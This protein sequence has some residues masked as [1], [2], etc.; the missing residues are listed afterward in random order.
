MEELRTGIYFTFDYFKC[1]FP[2]L[3]N[4][5]EFEKTEVDRLREEI[6]K[7]LNIDKDFY[8]EDYA[9][10]YKY[11]YTI[12]E[13][14]LLRCCGP[15]FSN[16]KPSCYI[17]FKGKGCREFEVLNP[18]K[19]WDDLLKHFVL[20]YD[21]NVKRIDIAIDHFDNKPVS[22]DW[23][24]N[25]LNN[26]YF[27]SNFKNRNFNLSGNIV[28]GRSITFGRH[29]NSLMLC[30]YEK[31]KEQEYH[32]EIVPEEHWTRYEMRFANNRADDFAY[33]YLTIS[34]MPLNEF[35]LSVFYQMLDIKEDN[36]RDTH[37]QANVETDPKWL[38][39]LGH[40]EK[41]KMVKATEYE[42][43]YISY[44]NWAEP[45]MGS[46]MLYLLATYKFELAS[47]LT[48]VLE[49]AVEV[50]D[51]YDKA[52]LKRINSYL[53]SKNLQLLTLEDIENMKPTLES[54]IEDRRLPF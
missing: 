31:K 15:E 46:F 17:E 52:K 12:G 45:L 4:K 36:N 2:L 9:A 48:K 7:Y 8:N 54:V 40:V 50:I 41:Y 51:K 10:R 32:G 14:I 34:D 49:L 11:S 27:A 47:T 5:E 16:G 22:F 24:L 53:K 38:E 18:D 13:H 28:E 42:S 26:G 43:T 1:T 37:H 29:G 44:Q 19:T 20:D 21:A 35:I 23:V 39:F 6:M 33:N 3:V 30:I 25:K